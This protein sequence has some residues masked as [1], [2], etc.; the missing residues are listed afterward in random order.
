MGESAFSSPRVAAKTPPTSDLSRD[1]LIVDGH[2]HITNA[3]YI[4]G[5]DPWKVQTTGTFDYARARQ[6]GLN[7]A[8]ENIYIDDKYGNYNYAVKQ[9]CRL[10]ETFYRVL[11]ANHDKMELALRSSDIRRIVANGKMAVVMALEGGFDMEG[12][13]DVLHLFYRLG[14]RMIQFTSHDET[15]VLADP[16]SPINGGEQ[17]WN[18]ISARAHEVIREMNRL[19]IIID[20]SH[21][22]ET[23]KNEIIA[24]SQAPVVTSHNGLRHFC[25]GIPGNLSDQTLLALAAKGG[26]MG[27][28]SAGW[29][30]SQ[31]AFD[32][33]KKGHWE[34]SASEPR[35]ANL[36]WPLLRSPDRE[37]GN[38]ISE[39]DAQTRDMWVNSWGFG[40]PWREN[41]EGAI[42]AGGPLPTIEDWADQ[43]DYVV[44]LV[45]A[46][47]ISLGL[48]LMAGGLWL[49][50]FDAT[51]YRS[52]AE[53]LTA[54]GY[55]PGT[56]REI[57][58]ENW[59]RMLDS[60]KVPQ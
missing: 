54:K 45:G 44:K 2:V 51:K 15:N 26:L 52:L 48:D 23:A 17:K 10:I 13:L 6:G 16:A 60:A 8:F 19:G 59:L 40:R 27:L 41:Q 5:I 12:D 37:Y 11:D 1:L 31:K 47:H 20:I 35:P 3:V 25:N 22:S 57:L 55:P 58:G 33:W 28:H 46:E 49:R 30:I 24:V 38:Y 53:A 34:P 9:A 32:W 42:R 56:V 43:V 14:A 18:G 21:A 4:Q 36:T 29:L 39:L 7:V 50:D